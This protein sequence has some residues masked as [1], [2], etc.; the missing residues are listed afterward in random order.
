MSLFDRNKK[1]EKTV[2]PVEKKAEA[3]KKAVKPKKAAAKKTP[4]KSAEAPKAVSK[5]KETASVL[6]RLVAA[7]AK[8]NALV[9]D[10]EDDL[11]KGCG[12]SGLHRRE[13]RQSL[14]DLGRKISNLVD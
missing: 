10:L 1:T 14:R 6:E 8:I 9:A 13:H 5:P 2:A 7:E 4:A 12:L 11:K 3:P